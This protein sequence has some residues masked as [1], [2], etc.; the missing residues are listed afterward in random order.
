M[1]RKA[2]A[3]SLALCAM[4]N[5]GHCD[6]ATAA[7]VGYRGEILYFNDDP[8]THSE[9]I[10]HHPDGLLVVEDG[11]I[12]ASGDYAAL[13]TQYPSIRVT[14]YGG[15]ILVP[16]FVDTHIHYPQTEMIGAYGSQLLGWLNHYTFPTEQKFSDETYARRVARDFLDQLIESGTTTALVFATSH[17]TSVD[18]LFEEAYARNMRIISGKV[19]MDRNAPEGLLD[20]PE[21]AYADSARLIEKWAGKGRIGYAVTPRFAPTSSDAE[22]EAAG[23]L[24]KKYPEVYLHTHLA[25]NKQEVAW[26]K[27]LFSWSRSYLD[28]YER[29]G[30][31]TSKSIFAHAIHLNDE[32]YRDLSK[33]RAGVAFC[34][35]SNLFLGSGLFNLDKARQFNVKVGLG[36]D[37]GAGTSFSILQ[38][39]N[40]AYKVTQLRK[41]FTDTPDAVTPLD[42]MQNLY[43][44]TLGGARALSLDGKIGSFLPGREADFLV[45]DPQSSR[46]MKLRTE[47]S[48]SIEDKLFA[49]EILG[50]DR[51]VLH[52]YVMGE[53]MK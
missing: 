27:Q 50:D 18:A 15:K 6:A 29:Y 52:T 7:A 24:L 41:A 49:I 51:T 46:V 11:K 34:P 19:L 17:A 9:A 40:E 38:T 53:R 32:D 25:E 47:H 13:H 12:V 22:L 36:T 39:M 28:V 10:Q 35:T 44:A 14:D 33:H 42:A 45:L 43:L 26:V 31:V 30:L 2:L 48:K 1:K 37:V 4:F 20:T 8:S 16:G 5:L 23:K 3:A 21:S